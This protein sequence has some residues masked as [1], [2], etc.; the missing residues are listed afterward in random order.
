MAREPDA[1]RA[2]IERYGSTFR[3]LRGCGRALAGRRAGREVVHNIHTC[4]NVIERATKDI[5]AMQIIGDCVRS[6]RSYGVMQARR[7]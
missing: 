7:R 3:A 6:G 2:W 5:H 1:C 4:R